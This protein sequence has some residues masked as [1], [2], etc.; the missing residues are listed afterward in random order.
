MWSRKT[1][2]LRMY[3]ADGISGMFKSIT[4]AH[5]AILIF[6]AAVGFA[7]HQSQENSVGIYVVLYILLFGMAAQFVV[8]LGD[9]FGYFKSI[10]HLTSKVLF[11][12][13]VGVSYPIVLLNGM[14]L[15]PIIALLVVPIGCVLGFV[16]I[17][18]MV[19]GLQTLRKL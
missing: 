16:L 9:I 3:L 10:R 8:I 14:K 13:W 4:L 12:L 7:L 18:I 17:T 5:L 11:S 6:L 15:D 19:Y 2:G 1:I